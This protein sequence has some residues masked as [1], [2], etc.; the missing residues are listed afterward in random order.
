MNK[1][2]EAGQ[3]P[4]LSRSD[5]VKN[6]KY[7][8]QCGDNYFKNRNEQSMIPLNFV[9]TQIDNI[10]DIKSQKSLLIT[11]DLIIVVMLN[12]GQSVDYIEKIMANLSE[13]AKDDIQ[14]LIERSKNNLDDLI[15]SRQS[16]VDILEDSPGG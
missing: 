5:R 4:I 7:I 15:S 11:I 2:Q 14:R 16:E 1:K 6:F 10:V 3:K 12:S 9:N 8:A 13:Q